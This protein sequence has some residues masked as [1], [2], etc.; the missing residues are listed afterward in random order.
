MNDVTNYFD[1]DF[2]DDDE[3]RRSGLQGQDNSS[4]TFGNRRR[5]EYRLRHWLSDEDLSDSPSQQVLAEL[6]DH[7]QAPSGTTSRTQRPTH[8]ASTRARRW[9]IVAHHGDLVTDTKGWMQWVAG[10]YKVKAIFGQLERGGE[11][12]SLHFQGGIVFH[13]AVRGATLERICGRNNHW[14]VCQ[15]DHDSNVEYATKEET[16]VDGP[17]W[18]PSEEEVRKAENRKCVLGDYFSGIQEGKTV[19]AI[20]QENQENFTVYVR[21]KR[22]LD[23]IQEEWFDSELTKPQAPTVLVFVGGTGKGKTRL[24]ADISQQLRRKGL[25]TWYNVVHSKYFHGYKGQTFVVLDEFDP[26]LFTQQYV[27]ALLDITT[28]SIPT[29]YGMHHWKADFIIICTNIQPENW[30]PMGNIPFATLDRRITHILDFD[31]FDL[32]YIWLRLTQNE[33]F[34]SFNLTKPT[35]SEWNIQQ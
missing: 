16:R 7:K 2:E 24:A 12:G 26:T 6:P 23:E 30:Y 20:A 11:T 19:T 8:A 17:F 31:A 10:Q 35:F 1:S 15:G 27:N 14:D 9:L 34:N 25:R 21:H 29:F 5:R 33:R 28:M 32:D 3:L 4:I 13:N 22:S 18:Y